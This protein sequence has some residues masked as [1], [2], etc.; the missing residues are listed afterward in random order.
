MAEALEGGRVTLEAAS[1]GQGQTRFF[2]VEIEGTTLSVFVIRDRD[3]VARAY[4]NRCP[5]VPKYGLDFGD[6]EVLDPEDG[7]IVCANHGARFLPECGTCVVGPCRGRQLWPMPCEEQDGCLVIRPSPL[8][9]GWP[10]GGREPTPTRPGPALV[11]P[12]LARSDES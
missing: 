4:A 5:H 8:P 7:L 12:P 2:E 6:G 3:G 1:L 9:T 10:F 11:L